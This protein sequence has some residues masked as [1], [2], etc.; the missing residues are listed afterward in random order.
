VS[1]A[2][3]PRIAPPLL[4]LV[5]ALALSGGVAGA[6]PEPTGAAAEGAAVPRT[7]APEAEGAA[8]PRTVAPEAEGAAVPRTVAP[9]A[10]GAAVPRT[11]A[12]E[13]TPE[14]RF[15]GGEPWAGRVT[16]ENAS[17]RLVGGPD[18]I[19]GIDDWAFGNGTICGVVSDPSRPLE[20]SPTGGFLVD[21][22]RCG[23]GDDHLASLVPLVNV[24]RD[25]VPRVESVE[26]F[27]DADGARLVTTARWNGIELQ[28]RYVVD[29]AEPRTLRIETEASRVASEGRLAL[30]ALLA[31]HPSGSLR[32]FTLDTRAPELS[33]GFDHP[34]SPG[35]DWRSILDG[36]ARADVQVMVADD[37]FGGGLAYGLELASAARIGA[38]GSETPLPIVAL[39]GV[40]FTVLGTFAR[41]FWL[42]GGPRLGLLELA[43]GPL[44]DLDAGDRLVVHHRLWVGG[45]PDVASVTDGLW[46]DG[47]RVEGWV[48]DP[49]ARLHVTRGG[50]PATFV[51][52]DAGGR[53][54][55]RVPEAGAYEVR[56][57]APGDREVYVPIAVPTEGRDLGTVALG[58]VGRVMLPRGEAMR[59]VF[60]GLGGTP[61]PH[62]R[63]DLLGL[64]FGGKPVRQA[65]LSSDVSLAGVPDD[66]ASVPMAPGRYRVLATRGL[67]W[68]VEETEIR[69]RA[70]EAVPLTIGI[71]RRVVPTPGWILAD[72]HV[73]TGASF[74]ATLPV[75]ER[76]R[77]FVAMGGEVLVSTEHDHV[78]DYR[79]VARAMGLADALRIV[80]GLE[81]TSVLRSTAAPHTTGHANAWPLEPEPYVHRG[82]ALPSQGVRLRTA[83]AA[84]RAR[85][86]ERLLQVN[87]PRR[88]E[89]VEDEESF[90]S[91][92]AVAGRPFDPTLPLD[93]EPNR[94]L[95]EADPET[96]LR[97]LDFDALE[98]LNGA[99]GTGL[100]AYKRT[101][102]DWLSLLRQ[103]VRRTGTA[104][105]DSHRLGQLVAIPANFVRVA[106]DRPT[107]VDTADLV[108]AV[109]RGAL[110]GSTGPFLGVRLG[111]AGAGEGAA[112][113]GE[114]W[115][116]PG[117]RF[118]GAAGELVVRVEAA[119]W[120]P[121]S[122]LRVY[123]DGALVY[124]GPVERGR[125]VRVPLEF[126]ADAFVTVEVE[127]DASGA[128]GARYRAVAPGFAPFAYTNPIFVDA[129]GDG[130]WT[131]PGLTPPLPPTITDPMGDRAADAP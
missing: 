106:E 62:L 85:G 60:R 44:M 117:D 61:D 127:G 51:R 45:R 35:E 96:G 12:P 47:P 71:P 40:P 55:F 57:V 50:F 4:G 42:G 110:V 28:S 14:A 52:P 26:A 24:S 91:H 93:R 1:R 82:G 77:S 59:L 75:R 7:V 9:E 46:A 11:V 21:L 116:G 19:G 76:L 115:A 29:R 65:A 74:D 112:D 108:A 87:H 58:G 8:V 97:D 114:A 100:R 73:H 25:N 69:V 113:S 122:E 101:R 84:L 32:T 64:R 83:I 70:G 36:L 123:T 43:Q 119:H 27:H 33:T 54:A 31:V 94:V 67:E 105:S 41:P 102:A 16:P 109:R 30:L 39:S 53:F 23:E 98:L 15:A 89:D 10:E 18:A 6:Q 121:V 124:A 22:G 37:G 72:L 17:L 3:P 120:V 128:G 66:P 79:P 88:G 130:R 48:D 63:D 81:V 68:S 107:R 118:T 38:D 5:L 95:L 103:G 80:P 126:A 111:A 78:V 125:P 86:G 20:V 34:A 90:L 104:N 131:E 99:T 13:A 92:L 49:D 129:D 56:A 2:R